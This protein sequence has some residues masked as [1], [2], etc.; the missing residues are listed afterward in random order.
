MKSVHTTTEQ[1]LNGYTFLSYYPLIY[2]KAVN[3][4]ILNLNF[5]DKDIENLFHSLFGVK[6]LSEIND[7]I[8]YIIREIFLKEIKNK[9]Q[10]PL[11]VIDHTKK[12]YKSLEISDKLLLFSKFFFVYDFVTKKFLEKRIEYLLKNLETI[13][14]KEDLKKSVEGVLFNHDGWWNN[15]YGP[16]IDTNSKEILLEALNHKEILD[17]YKNNDYAAYTRFFLTLGYRLF[18]ANEEKKAIKIVKNIAKKNRFGYIK[19]YLSDHL[20]YKIKSPFKYLLA[21]VGSYNSFIRYQTNCYMFLYRSAKK[22]HE[23]NKYLKKAI[24]INNVE[25]IFFRTVLKNLIERGTVNR[26][27]LS[28]RPQHHF[29]II[30]ILIDKAIFFPK[31]KEE[32]IVEIKYHLLNAMETIID[33]YYSKYSIDLNYFIL[34]ELFFIIFYYLEKIE[35]INIQEY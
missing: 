33:N 29:K 19:N 8:Y 28:I 17:N 23:R 35:G 22:K 7:R 24:K 31:K 10:L 12:T 16:L 4:K 25:K 14:K 11:G 30:E 3:Y 5:K 26:L 21:N 2:K 34:T 9:D 15:Y 13:K 32:T 27:N 6:N 18:E 20:P 1:E